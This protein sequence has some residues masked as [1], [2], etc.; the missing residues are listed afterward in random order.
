MLHNYLLQFIHPVTRENL[1]FELPL[2][3]IFN[4]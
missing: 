3:K 2:P 4:I 1:K